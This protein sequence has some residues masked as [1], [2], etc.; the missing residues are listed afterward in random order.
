[1]DHFPTE[2]LQSLHDL[3]LDN[4]TLLVSPLLFH[5][6]GPLCLLPPT[7]SP[8]LWTYISLCSSASASPPSLVRR[9][10]RALTHKGHQLP[11]LLLF[12]LSNVPCFLPPLQASQVLPGFMAATFPPPPRA[13]PSSPSIPPPQHHAPPSAA[14]PTNSPTIIPFLPYF[15]EIRVIH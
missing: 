7:P 10:F 2:L 9:G 13:T 15:P 4:F 8:W 1:M 5:S 3:V 14:H 11:P 12:I 6:S